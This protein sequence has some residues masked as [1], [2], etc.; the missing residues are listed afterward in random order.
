MPDS[1]ANIDGLAR[2]PIRVAAVQTEVTTDPVANGRAVRAA[3]RQAADGGARLAHFCEGALSGYA[4]QDKPHFDGWRIGWEPVRDELDRTAQLAG[5]LG[6]WVVIGGNHQLTGGHRP[7][8]SL[9]IINDRGELVDRYDKRFCS[10]AEITRFYTPGTHVCTFEVDTFRFGCLLCI[11]VNFPE[12]WVEQGALDVDCVLFST[13]S[14]DPIFDILARGHA[15]ANGFWV[16]VAVPTQHAHAM[17]SGVIGPHGHR[18]ASAPADQPAVVCVDL[19]RTD[20]DLD[21]ALH[22]ARPWRRLA[23]TGALYPARQVD[24]PRSSDR[25]CR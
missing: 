8:N 6:I 14:D 16:S 1:D 22:K 3:L 20:P 5:E 23:R 4:G 17:P 18:L 24:D 25:T 12:L 11:E 10:H 15:A 9:W 7:H 19:D 13:F 2:R 21:V